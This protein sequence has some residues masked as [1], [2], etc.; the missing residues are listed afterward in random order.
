[1]ASISDFTT[2]ASGPAPGSP[3]GLLTLLSEQDYRAL[4]PHLEKVQIKLR[5]AIAERGRPLCYVYF[6][7]TAVLS[8]LALM[9][10]G[11]AVEVGT[12]GSEGLAGI[13][14]L[15]GSE[16]AVDTIICQIEGDALRM[17]AAAFRQAI[18]GDTPLRRI[19]QRYLQ[20]YLSPRA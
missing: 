9:Q 6:P 16:Q 3:N 8:V 15:V 17:P 2:S 12:V 18:D 14:V 10:D 4:K 13:D 7:Q 20:A 5:Q 19:A 11:A 1:M